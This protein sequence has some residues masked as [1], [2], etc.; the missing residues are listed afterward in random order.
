MA[1]FVR[2]TA[3]AKG[4]K[5]GNRLWLAVAVVIYGRRLIQRL[6]RGGPEVVYSETLA[7]GESL[8]IEHQRDAAI[9]EG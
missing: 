6:G 9:M 7:P 8:V 3:I 4:V 5:G 1:G 2:R